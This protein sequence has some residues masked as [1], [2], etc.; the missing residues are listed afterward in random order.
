MS[1]PSTIPDIPPIPE[2]LD[3]LAVTKALAAAAHPGIVNELAFRASCNDIS[4]TSLLAI[5]EHLYK[6]SGLSAKQEAKPQGSFIFNIHMG[7]NDITISGGPEPVDVET[8]KPPVLAQFAGELGAPPP[9]MASKT[10]N[11]HTELAFE[12]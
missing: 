4:T 6:V 3:P 2:G 9:F 5:S 1:H 8:E 10:G 11:L 7:G 12:A